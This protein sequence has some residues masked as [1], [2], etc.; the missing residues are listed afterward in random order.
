M[1]IQ[2][3]ARSV[4]L[5]KRKI[6][7]IEEI[8]LLLVNPHNRPC[9]SCIKKCSCSNSITCD[10]DCSLSCPLIT[11][12]LSSD[13]NKYPIEKHIVPLVFTLNQMDVCKTCW[14]CEGHN[15]VHTVLNK[16]PQVW[17]YSDSIVLIRLLDD[18]LSS[19]RC[20]KLTHY[21]WQIN[22]TYSAADCEYNTFS[23][24]PELSLIKNADL[25]LLQKDIEQISKYF[26]EALLKAS[27]E[28]LKSYNRLLVEFGNE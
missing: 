18:C 26:P 24:K 5:L 1:K 9:D 25:A 4:E 17:F 12:Q 19:F 2:Q 11:E 15:D 10:C 6:R 21:Q 23:I 13:R 3:P 16:L 28:Q 22:I 20:H 7:E 14:S 8:V 27:N